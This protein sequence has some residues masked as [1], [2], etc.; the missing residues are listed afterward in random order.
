MLMFFVSFYFDVRWLRRRK[1]S[2]WPWKLLALFFLL[3]SVLAYEIF[4]PLFCINVIIAWYVIQRNRDALTAHELSLRDMV[5]SQ[6]LNI[7]LILLVGTFKGMVSVRPIS[8]HIVGSIVFFS[9]VLIKSLYVGLGIYGVGLPKT[10][11][12]AISTGIQPY[13]ILLSVL[14][15]LATFVYLSRISPELPADGN[16][17]ISPLTLI[18]SGFAIFVVGYSIFLTTNQIVVASTGIGN[19]TNIAASIGVAL[20]QV[21]GLFW[22]SSIFRIPSIRKNVQI[23]GIAML[24]M[25]SL[26]INSD[27]A[28]YWTDAYSREKTVLAGILDDNPHLEPQSTLI[29]DGVCPYEGPAIVFESWWDLAGALRIEYLDKSLEAD[30]VTP[31]MTIEPGGLRASIY[32]GGLQH[33][34]PYDNL[35]IYNYQDKQ[36]YEIPDE[37]SARR[38]FKSINPDFDSNCPPGEAGTGVAI[39]HLF[40]RLEG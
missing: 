10:V 34:H 4:M 1:S 13:L 18:G 23:A 36:T 6:G 9:R 14:I 25:I 40:E 35:K 29:L 3:L 31:F 17:P 15:G 19:R 16:H 33:I 5:S 28:T 20:I 37:L 32:W 22:L 11:S 27:I 26:L 38:Y 12:Q 21:G 2:G 39:Y 8:K 24:C 30:V 7:F